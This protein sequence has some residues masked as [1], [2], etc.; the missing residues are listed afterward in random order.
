ML[1]YDGRPRT[2]KK[3]HHSTLL[4]RSPAHK[5]NAAEMDGFLREQIAATASLKEMIVCECLLSINYPPLMTQ[6]A[7]LQATFGPVNEHKTPT[8][9]YAKFDVIVQKF[10]TVFVARGIVYLK[11]ADGEVTLNDHRRWRLLREG[12]S[13][14]GVLSAMEKLWNEMQA[15]DT[16][17]PVMKGETH[18]LYRW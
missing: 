12:R 11:P 16:K 4:I 10:E 18:A 6:P 2:Q 7:Q 15:M 8:N 3:Q 13:E 17:D 14:D 1:G 9:T 5:S